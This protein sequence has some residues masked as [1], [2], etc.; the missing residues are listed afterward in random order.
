M[1][2]KYV[3]SKKVIIKQ[4]LSLFSTVIQQRGLISGRAYNRMYFFCFQVDGAI[5]GWAYNRNFTV[6]A[7]NLKP[8]VMR[9]AMLQSGF[10]SF[11]LILV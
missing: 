7:K 3:F 9:S 2:I 8:G 1:F 10:I 11:A 6:W 5:T 4:H